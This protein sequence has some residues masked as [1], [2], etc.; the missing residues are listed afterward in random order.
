[1][2]RRRGSLGVVVGWETGSSLSGPRLAK[3]QYKKAPVKS[4]N[5]II[6]M[7]LCLDLIPVASSA[8]Q[9]TCLCVAL[10]EQATEAT[11]QSRGT[12]G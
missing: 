1:M 3:M 11:T 7:T 6:G 12:G 5:E 2:L 9:R 8:N 4:T 10:D